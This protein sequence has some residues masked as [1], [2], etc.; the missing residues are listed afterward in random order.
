MKRLFILLL[1][2]SFAACHTPPES[3]EKGV[4]NSTE[5]NW[6]KAIEEF[7]KVTEED[8]DWLD[9]A[10]DRKNEAF[11]PL[12]NEGD[13]KKTFRILAK[14]IDDDDFFFAATDSIESHFFRLIE[15]GKADSVLDLL[16]LHKAKLEEYIDTVFTHSLIV[17]CEDSLFMGV[18]AGTGSLKNQEIYFKREGKDF[19]AYSNKSLSGWIKDGIIYKELVYAGNKS[20]NAKPKVFRTD[21]WGGSSSYYSKKG[22]IELLNR[23]TI[24]VT[25]ETLGSE[26]IFCR[27]KD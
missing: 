23:D 18:W 14:Y 15:K 1:A 21:Y 2:I 22:G 26:D 7:N 8:K 9:S 10:T 16:E 11:M 25:Y 17:Q 3:Y 5:K 13:W 20:W 12:M 19:H 6:D 4:A 24:K 27:K